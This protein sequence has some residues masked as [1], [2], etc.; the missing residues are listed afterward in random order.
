MSASEKLT[1]NYATHNIFCDVC[2][3]HLL[4]IKISDIT[5]PELKI[6]AKCP[7]CSNTTFN[8]KFDNIVFTSPANGLI[9]LDVRTE[10]NYNN[11]VVTNIDTLVILG[12]GKE[13]G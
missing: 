4:V 1:N 7:Y 3:K 8:T 11:K 13:N 10:S 6:K 9:M 12:K 5:G 2:K